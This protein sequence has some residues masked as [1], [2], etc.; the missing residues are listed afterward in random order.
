MALSPRKKKAA[1]KGGDS[2][3]FEIVRFP[4]PELPGSGSKGRSQMLLSVETPL[5][6]YM[7]NHK[8]QWQN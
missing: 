3:V 4:T 2:S 7:V 5:A 6:V 1:W 8:E